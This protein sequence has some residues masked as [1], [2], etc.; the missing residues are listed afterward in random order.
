M[1]HLDSPNDEH[2]RHIRPIAMP[3]QSRI[4]QKR[5]ENP[6]ANADFWPQAECLTNFQHSNARVLRSGSLYGPDF[7]RVPDRFFFGF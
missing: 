4:L 3:I 7:P 1:G 6:V 2:G 5:A